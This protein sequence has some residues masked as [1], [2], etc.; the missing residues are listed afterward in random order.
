[1]R[2]KFLMISIT[3]CPHRSKVSK[4]HKSLS[5]RKQFEMSNNPDKNE[6]LGVNLGRGHN[7]GRRRQAR[8][9]SS[10]GAV[11]MI[12]DNFSI[13][14]TNCAITLRYTR[15]HAARIFLDAARGNGIRISRIS[16]RFWSTTQ[17][18]YVGRNFA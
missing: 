16:L 11:P 10:I 3:K 6:V 14:G 17:Y 2:F 4:T 9:I 12:W 7:R 13:L 18:V 8:A 1:M 5:N 15:A